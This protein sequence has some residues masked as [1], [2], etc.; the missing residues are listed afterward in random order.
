MIYTVFSKENRK[1]LGTATGYIALAVFFV[2][3]WLFCWVLPATSFI[4]YGFSEMGTFFELAPYLFVFLIP[5]LTM[6]LFAEEFQAGTFEL[7]IT[8]PISV[9]KITLG[10]F[11]SAW[12]L[13]FIA[14]IFTLI[15]FVSLYLLGNPIGNIDISGAFGSYLGLFLLCGVFCA[16]G[17][18]CSSLTDNQIIAFILALTISYLL[19]DGIGQLAAIDW[20]QGSLSYFL[21]N[22]S[23]Y[24]HY[25]AMGRGVVDSRDVIYLISLIVLFLIFTKLSVGTRLLR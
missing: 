5:A 4:E 10:K 1:Y 25:E 3:L 8:K 21:Q 17:I 19:Y 12:F 15:Y 7:L 14:L 16:I 18:F 2:A 6:R 20:F 24:T 9:L 11:F 22:A 13:V 23:I